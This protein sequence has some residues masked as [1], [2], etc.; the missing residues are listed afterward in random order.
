MNLANFEPKAAQ[1]SLLQ[2][3]N[4]GKA[5]ELVLAAEDIHLMIESGSSD[6]DKLAVVTLLVLG[7]LVLD[8]LPPARFAL[9][10]L[11]NNLRS[12]PLP[13]ALLELLASAYARN[14]ENI[15]PRVTK[16]VELVDGPLYLS[17]ELADSVK[18]LAAQFLDSFRQLTFAL[19]SKSHSSLPVAQA[20]VYLGL[21]LR[22]LSSAIESLG[23][24][25][26]EAE[27]TIC[28]PRVPRTNKAF[29]LG[30][31]T[32]TLSTFETLSKVS[33]RLELPL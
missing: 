10:R 22:D 26:D 33:S 19:L 23:W 4:E 31:N 8:N 27:Q 14:Y 2:L 9:T 32:S 25:I 5:S 20:Q 17:L 1:A 7:Y 16:L 18:R 24:N 11:P 6:E 28:S 13:R 21:S 30:I 29:E 3:A 15:Y 12:Q